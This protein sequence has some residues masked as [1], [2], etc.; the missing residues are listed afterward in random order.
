MTTAAG[1]QRAY[2]AY[3]HDLDYSRNVTNAGRGYRNQIIV[4]N[5]EIEEDR[6]RYYLGVLEGSQAEE[7]VEEVEVDPLSIDIVLLR[8]Q[9]EGLRAQL[10]GLNLPNW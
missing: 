9:L 6:D 10:Q 7:R 3:N 8:A 2:F 5:P 1:E 4:E